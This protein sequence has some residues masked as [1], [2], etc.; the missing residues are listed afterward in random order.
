VP[1]LGH[2]MQGRKLRGWIVFALLFGLFACGTWLADGTNLSRERHFYYWSGQ[3]LLGG[4]ALFLESIAGRASVTRELPLADVGLLYACM[5]GLLN[6][7][8]MLDV[9]GVAEERWMQPA[10]RDTVGAGATPGPS[11]ES[12][13]TTSGEVPV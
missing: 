6:V 2:W 4:P 11:A 7:L 8:A 12:N 9:W 1:G 3:F 5:A 10:A 13:P